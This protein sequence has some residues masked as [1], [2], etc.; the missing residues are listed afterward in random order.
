MQNIEITI[1]QQGVALLSL[2]RPEVLNALNVPLLDD[3]CQAL[4][5]L[6]ADEKLKA[7]V[8]T[9]RGRGFCAGADLSALGQGAAPGD[10]IGQMVS[11]QMQSHFNP[12]MEL[13][14]HFP[15]PTICAI[16]GIAAGGGAAIALCA[17]IV[18]A[19]R[20]ASLKFVQVQALGIV[21]DLGANWLLP[22]I[23]GRSRALGA[24]LLGDSLKAAQLQEWGLVWECVDAD[25][26]LPRA[27]EVGSRLAAVPAATVLATRQIIDAAGKSSFTAALEQERL[28]QRELC[29]LPV[30]SESV[31]RFMSQ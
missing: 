25:Q 2:N 17:D 3:L 26:L 24:C 15:R 13:L 19:S 9:G 4:R 30:F 28:A 5:E 18:L 20:D 1:D 6:A 8:V 22:R 14:Y 11:A 31:A 27:M 29:D 16:N 21:A 12:A 23:A 10:S 7:L